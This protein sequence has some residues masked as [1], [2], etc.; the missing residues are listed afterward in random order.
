MY[1]AAYAT[2]I[3]RYAAGTGTPC[4]TSDL[5]SNCARFGRTQ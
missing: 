3:A 2:A 4:T 1:A 5:M